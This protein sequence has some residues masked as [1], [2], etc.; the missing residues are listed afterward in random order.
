MSSTRQDGTEAVSIA[1]PQVAWFWN[2]TGGLVEGCSSQFQD[3]G[4]SCVASSWPSQTMQLCSLLCTVSNRLLALSLISAN[5][6][7]AIDGIGWIGLSFVYSALL[8]QRHSRS[9]RYDPPPSPPSQLH[10]DFNT[11]STPGT[12]KCCS[13]DHLIPRAVQ[14]ASGPAVLPRVPSRGCFRNAWAVSLPL[15]AL[16]IQ[17]GSA[18]ARSTSPHHLSLPASL[19]LPLLYHP[20]P[21]LSLVWLVLCSYCRYLAVVILRVSLLCNP[22]QLFL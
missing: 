19:S 15:C 18:H 10:R 22:F 12:G 9:G 13:R 5:A 6:T 14:S 17:P 16:H 11:T 8:W 7:S 4:R 3:W 2:T 1:P 20:F 21:V